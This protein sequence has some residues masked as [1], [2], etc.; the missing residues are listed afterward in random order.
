[1]VKKDKNLK[2][3]ARS[4]IAYTEPQSYVSE[5]YRTLRTN[6]N[7][8]SP[9]ENIQTIVITSAGPA[10]GKST[11]AANLAVVYAQEGK[12]ILLVDGD[13]RKPTMHHTFKIRNIMGLSSILG[14]QVSLKAAIKKTGVNGLDIL[15]SGQIPPN[16]AELLASKS[17]DVLLDQLKSK[18]DL[19]IFDSPPMLSV[20]DAQILAYKCD[21]VILVLNSKS[22]EK[23]QAIK[24]KEAIAVSK[25][26]LIGVVLNNYS[27]SK[28]NYYNTYSQTIS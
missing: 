12:N 10:E 16:P 18:Y 19:I 20:T 26:K 15:T 8:S 28:E 1:M 5:Q 4:L 25:S 13:L 17:M 21:G 11:T 9:D 3:G 24:A 2:Y 14:R 7:F 6:I 27:N 22:T 23:Q